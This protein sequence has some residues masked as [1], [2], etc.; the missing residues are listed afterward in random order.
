MSAQD[1]VLEARLEA[2]PGRLYERVWVS[3][4]PTLDDLFAQVWHRFKMAEHGVAITRT[5]VLL[6]VEHVGLV[7][8]VTDFLEGYR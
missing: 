6:M 5:C 8:D 2:V 7:V 1:L 3:G 4:D